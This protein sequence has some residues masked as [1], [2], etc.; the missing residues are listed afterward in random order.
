M[1]NISLQRQILS[2]DIGAE[3]IVVVLLEKTAEGVRTLGVWI[4]FRRSQSK[5]EW[6]QLILKKWIE[7]QKWKGKTAY[8]VHSQIPCVIQRL[9]IP[10]VP[11]AELKNAIYWQIK[12]QISYPVEK[13]AIEYRII[14]EETPPKGGV[15]KLDLLAAVVSETEIKR[16]TDQIE[17]LGLHVKKIGIVPT[18]LESCLRQCPYREQSV[19]LLEMG[20]EVTHLVIFQKEK[21]QFHRQLQV[22]GKTITESLTGSIIS[23]SGRVD[24]SPEEAERLKRKYGIPERN[25]TEHDSGLA[26]S[27]QK[28]GVMMRP[29]LEKLANEMRQTID[30]YRFQFTQNDQ[31]IET[32]LVSGGGAELKGLCRFL[33]ESFGLS[34]YVL[35]LPDT[36]KG[37]VHMENT[38]GLNA[39]VGLALEDLN[40]FNFLPLSYRLKSLRKFQ[41][42]LLRVLGIGMV[43]L[44]LTAY[45]YM[46]WHLKQINLE[47]NTMRETLNNMRMIVE[48]KKEIDERNRLLST[49]HQREQL[50]LNLMVDISKITPPNLLLDE[51]IFDREKGELLLRGVLFVHDAKA[52]K[53]LSDIIEELHKSQWIHHAKLVTTQQVQQ[54][55]QEAE[56]FEILCEFPR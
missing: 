37:N 2:L 11:T 31:K 54:Q 10:Q 43:A 32:I 49:L 44:I 39:A 48:L 14:D 25:T 6:W 29:A 4:E 5:E 52:S 35:N 55:N 12:D 27:L 53:E 7:Q 15:K 19:V 33:K 47:L 8:V 41:K 42:G 24:I 1:R 16:L 34:V 20:S 46:H 40:H 21:I 22:T 45:L 38:L 30:Y 56:R 3:K 51:L 23:E 9:Q 28:L 13:A 26:I 50:C 36:F 18:A 17:E